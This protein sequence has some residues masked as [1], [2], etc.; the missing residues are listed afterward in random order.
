[1]ACT[2]LPWEFHLEFFL[3]YLTAHAPS[4]NP[5]T[6]CFQYSEIIFYRGSF[7]WEFL[8]LYTLESTNLTALLLSLSLSL[9]QGNKS[10]HSWLSWMDR[11]SQRAELDP[12]MAQ[13]QVKFTSCRK[14]RKYNFISSIVEAPEK[15]EGHQKY[16]GGL[17]HHRKRFVP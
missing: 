17:I 4:L 10:H 7:P 8:L 11:G 2:S 5:H 1:M 12:V 16:G 15:G 6:P 14:L 3:P 13:H 9:L